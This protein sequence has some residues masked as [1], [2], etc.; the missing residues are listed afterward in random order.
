MVGIEPL[1]I[2]RMGHDSLSRSEFKPMWIHPAR[3]A[4]RSAYSRWHDRSNLIKEPLFLELSQSV[5]K[6]TTPQ[7]FTGLTNSFEFDLIYASSFS[8]QDVRSID[9][10]YGELDS[11]IRHGLKIGVLQLRPL[12][13][14][15]PL[16]SRVQDMLNDGSLSLV[17]CDEVLT[18]EFLLIR[19]VRPLQ[20]QPALPWNIKAKHTIV[21]TQENLSTQP[22]AEIAPKGTYLEHFL[23]PSKNEFSIDLVSKNMGNLG[24]QPKWIPTSEWQGIQLNQLDFETFSDMKNWNIEEFISKIIVVTD[25]S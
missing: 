13:I 19:K 15:R 17:M 3:Q 25:R 16:D 9:Q 4:Y 2:I 22:A 23:H 5:R 7:R 11:L 1:S 14:D 24:L 20:I 12:Q 6:F 18:T 10:Q 21:S 8:H